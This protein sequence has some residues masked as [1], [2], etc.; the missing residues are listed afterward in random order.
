MCARPC[1]NG[2]IARPGVC[3]DGIPSRVGEADG[4][5]LRLYR[6]VGGLGEHGIQTLGV[7]RFRWVEREG[8]SID[9]T[10]AHNVVGIAIGT[11]IVAIA[12]IP[13]VVLCD[14]VVNGRA[15][16][17]GHILLCP[18]I[19]TSGLVLGHVVIGQRGI[20]CC[21]EDVGVVAHNRV[22]VLNFCTLFFSDI[23]INLFVVGRAVRVEGEGEVVNAIFGDGIVT[24]VTVPAVGDRPCLVFGN[25]VLD[26]CS[27]GERNVLKRLG[28][29]A[30]VAQNHEV[31]LCRGC[32]F[33][34]EY[35]SRLAD[36][37]VGVLN[38]SDGARALVLAFN[39]QCP[40]DRCIGATS[41]CGGEGVGGIAGSAVLQGYIVGASNPS[42]RRIERDGT[43]ANPC[44]V[45]TQL[46][47]QVTFGV[48][49][50][51]GIGIDLVCRNFCECSDTT[52]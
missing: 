28:V 33:C 13:C 9:A 41:P 1:C 17:N 44:V 3:I 8:N 47:I 24:V 32:P 16:L 6:Q 12:D 14:L 20:P 43:I 15:G 27:I 48:G 31:I 40:T 38:G 51:K 26:S 52:P 7:N 11:G 37:G 25:L 30:I 45:W 35:G 50:I 39:L 19:D 46:E 22:G 18:S 4:E 5:V 10:L 2:S 21:S 36:D 49:Q 42:T 23:D 34:A 29:L